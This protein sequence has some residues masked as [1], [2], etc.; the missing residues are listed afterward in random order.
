MLND[1]VKCPVKL[2]SVGSKYLVTYLGTGK[3]KGVIE[4]S[5]QIYQPFNAGIQ[6]LR[7]TQPDEI[8]T[9]NF[10]S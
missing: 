2:I 1:R 3:G 6:S 7:A 4:F 9:G 8:F 10:A 5:S